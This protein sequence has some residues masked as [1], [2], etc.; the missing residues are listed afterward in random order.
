MKAN[1]WR[2]FIITNNITNSST[3]VLS[4]WY[5]MF[6]ICGDFGLC[7]WLCKVYF[8]PHLKSCTITYTVQTSHKIVMADNLFQNLHS[9]CSSVY[10][11]GQILLT[12]ARKCA[13]IWSIFVFHKY[14]TPHNVTLSRFL[15][16]GAFSLQLPYFTGKI[17]VYIKTTTYC[18]HF[19]LVV[20]AL[21]AHE[22]HMHMITTQQTSK[23][24][25]RNELQWRDSRVSLKCENQH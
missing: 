20:G 12:Q 8:C 2:P 7:T 15:Y 13:T 16:A 23:P 6:T 25:L 1:F 9:A 24:S 10:L 18:L 22:K 3:C 4:T 5:T 19:V 21:A 11:W 17:T 14:V